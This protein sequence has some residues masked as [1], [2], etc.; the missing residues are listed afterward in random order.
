[1][2]NI[3]KQAVTTNTEKLKGVREETNITPHQLLW[4]N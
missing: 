2:Q 3:K 4:R 1:M